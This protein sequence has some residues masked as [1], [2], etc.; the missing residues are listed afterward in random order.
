MIH[1]LAQDLS[2]IFARLG[3]WPTDVPLDALQA[4][5]RYAVQHIPQGGT[6]ADVTPGTGKHTVILAAACYR[7]NAKLFVSP[8]PNQQP[9]EQHWL[10]RAY[11]LFKLKDVVDASP[12]MVQPPDFIAIRNNSDVAAQVYN[13]MKADSLV[14]C[15]R[16][17]PT[18]A[19][20]E[21]VGNG[22]GVWRRSRPE[23]KLVPKQFIA[24]PNS[25]HVKETPDVILLPEVADGTK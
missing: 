17:Q 5:W 20:A 24:A 11:R 19:P 1:T 13:Q 2:V 3:A 14:F 6:A 23:L 12:T 16:C 7:N 21:N 22:Y 9:I 8:E 10:Q 4:L 25:P 15:V 18:T